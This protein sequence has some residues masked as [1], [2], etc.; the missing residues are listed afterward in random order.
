MK[1]EIYLV[2]NV[3]NK[4]YYVGKT[5]QGIKRRWICHA[6]DATASK[7][8]QAVNN[9]FYSAIRK[10]GRENFLVEKLCE[11]P[12]NETANESERF[13]IWILAANKKSFG[14]NS[15]VGGDG[16]VGYTA[17]VLEKMRKAH[18]GKKRGPASPERKAK[19]S[20][21]NKGRP[22]RFKGIPLSEETK[23]K[24]SAAKKGRSVSAETREKIRKTLAGRQM[25]QEIR[26][27]ISWATKGRAGRTPSEETKR[28]ISAS[29]MGKKPSEGVRRKM[30]LAKKEKGCQKKPKNV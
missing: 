22:S 19:I 9:Y 27:K 15:T 6:S 20:A 23:R 25:P 17:E 12:D 14:Y 3:I 11:C 24:I 26:D 7:R 5:R 29:N 28:R 1:Y 16:N 2:T 18:L 13:M 30:S 8:P 4:K 10:Y 21:A